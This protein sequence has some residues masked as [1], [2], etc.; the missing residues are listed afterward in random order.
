MALGFPLLIDLVDNNCIVFGGSEEAAARAATLLQ[1]G[2]KV[3]VISPSLCPAL[4]DL[5]EA[6]RVRYIPRRYYRGDCTSS[7]L[8]VAAT[9]NMNIDLAIAA[10]CKA[11]AIA[12]NVQSD[13]TY[14]TFRFPTVVMPEPDAALTVIGTDAETTDRWRKTVQDTFPPR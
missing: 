11:K 10:E 9:G 4:R 14:G 2:A 12:I 5:E 7:Y 1:F 13:E 3:T 6:G 8:C